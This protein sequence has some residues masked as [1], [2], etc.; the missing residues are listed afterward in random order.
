MYNLS[1]SSRNE[2]ILLVVDYMSKWVEVVSTKTTETTAIFKFLWK[3]IFSR[4]AVF[5]AI[6]G[7]QSLILTIALL[8]HY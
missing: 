5:R 6:I 1:I 3:N 8:M 4:Y 2:Y 7:D